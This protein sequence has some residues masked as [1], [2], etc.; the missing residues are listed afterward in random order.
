MTDGLAKGTAGTPGP[1]RPF[2]IVADLARSLP[3]EECADRRA[4]GAVSGPDGHVL[5]YGRPRGA[6]GAAGWGAS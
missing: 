5:F 6:G 4:G 2:L 1:A 3:L